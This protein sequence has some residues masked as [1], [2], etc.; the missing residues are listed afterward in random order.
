MSTLVVKDLTESVELDR[1]AM[2]VI[3]GGARNRQVMPGGTI[4]RSTRII[5]YPATIPFRPTAGKK[6]STRK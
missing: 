3:A 1:K 4:L 5:D 6:A 2:R